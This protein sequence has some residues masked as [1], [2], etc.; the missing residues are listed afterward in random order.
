M[1]NGTTGQPWDPT[2]TMGTGEG[3]V[4]L[5]PPPVAKLDARTMSSDLRSMQ[6]SGGAMPRPYAPQ[7]VPSAP[8]AP[9]PTRMPAPPVPVPTVPQPAST[10]PTPAAALYSA[11]IEKKGGKNIFIISLVATLIVGLGALGY[12]VLYPMIFGESTVPPPVSD[13][14]G[15]L[16]LPSVPNP[17]PIPAEEPILGPAPAP[18]NSPS[19]DENS[20]TPTPA[21]TT[22]HA[23]FFKIGADDTKNFTL[24]NLTFASLKSLLS[25]ETSDVPLLTELI[26]KNAAGNIMTF[27]QFAETAFPTV[28]TPP[29][30][31]QFET[32]FTF[33][34]LTNQKGTWLGFVAKKKPSSAPSLVALETSAALQNFFLKTPGTMQIWK[35]GKAGATDTRY[36]SFQLPGAGFNYGWSGD[37]LVVSASYDAFKEA[38]RRLE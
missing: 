34:S 13:T 7:N 5:A 15:E 30:A 38:L 23:S 26:G 37:Y 1:E 17:N 32:D 20:G 8:A 9:V 29:V 11:P 22:E 10:A 28:F 6:Q 35:V 14:P 16:P 3:E 31:A 25:F 4:P 24:T 33:F 36:A 21:L 12:F 27:G 2:K 19:P 18:V